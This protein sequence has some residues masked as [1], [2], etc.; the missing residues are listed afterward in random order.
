MPF[1]TITIL[2]VPSVLAYLLGQKDV[3]SAVT[4]T[5]FG[6]MKWSTLYMVTFTPF[7]VPLGCLFELVDYKNYKDRKKKIRAKENQIEKL[8]EFL[9]IKKEELIKLKKDKTREHENREFRKEKIDN[10]LNENILND[11]LS[12]SYDVGYNAD[13][14]YKYLQKGTLEKKLEKNYTE[15]GINFTKEY[16]EEKGPTLVKRKK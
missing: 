1:V 7:F 9:E 2:I 6:K 15:E 14:Y 12:V 5:I 11:L 16:L 8:K 13:K 3:F 10:S 4:N